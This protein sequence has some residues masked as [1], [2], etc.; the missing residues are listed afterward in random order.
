MSIKHFNQDDPKLTDFV[1]G[2]LDQNESKLIQSHIDQCA[3]CND[4]VKELRELTDL[5]STSMISD[6]PLKLPEESHQE[7]ELALASDS[8]TVSTHTDHSHKTGRAS[9]Q[10]LLIATCITI[11]TFFVMITFF[12]VNNS[13]FKETADIDTGLKYQP[14]KNIRETNIPGQQI[15]QLD[16]NQKS[17]GT[18]AGEIKTTDFSVVSKS[19][20][21]SANGQSVPSQS[22]TQ[23]SGN[24]TKKAYVIDIG[25]KAKKG[26]T[27]LANKA[28]EP[29]P[30]EVQFKQGEFT[31][32]APKFKDPAIQTNNTPSSRFDFVQ[33][34]NQPQHRSNRNI[35]LSYGGGLNK[36]NMLYER[37]P[38]TADLA[39][40]NQQTH[41]NNLSTYNSTEQYGKTPVLDTKKSRNLTAALGVNEA[42]PFSLYEGT[43]RRR[44]RQE[45][46]SFISQ[47]PTRPGYRIRNQHARI[48]ENKFLKP[49]EEPLSTFSVDVDTATYSIVRSYINKRRIPPQ[50]AVRIEEMVNY[51]TYEDAPPENQKQPFACH[52][53]TGPCPWNKKHQ[54]VRI[55]IK[56]K[57]IPVKKR[58]ACNLVFLIDV[59]GSMD[60]PDKLPLVKSGL[61]I[62]TRNLTEN[63]RISIVTYSGNAGLVLPPTDGS[64]KKEIVEKIHSLKAKGSTNGEAGLLLAYEQARKNENSERISRVI[65]CTD[66]DFNV[67]MSDDD[68]MVKLIQTEANEGI[69][70]LSVLGFGM[71]NLKDSKLEKLADNGNGNYAY[72]DNRQEAK[73]VFH[74]EING[75]LIT[76]A[77]DVKVQVEF[78]PAQVGSYRLI[79]YS[80]RVMQHHEF[81]DDSKDA[82]DIGAGHHVTVLYEIAP[83]GVPVNT[84]TDDLK[85]QKKPVQPEE[86]NNGSSEWLTCKIRYKKPEGKK[87][88]KLEFV[89]DPE[90]IKTSTLSNDFHWSSAVTAYGLLLSRS[91]YQGK[92]NFELILNLAEKGIGPDPT[93]RRLEFIDLVRKTE[94]ML[95]P[96]KKIETSDTNSEIKKELS[97][98]RQLVNEK[99]KHIGD[100]ERQLEL[101]QKLNESRKKI[102]DLLKPAPEEQADKA[103]KK[104]PIKLIPPADTLVP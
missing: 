86:K 52:L 29:D 7:I 85:Y 40:P 38:E 36:N 41:T 60:E 55:G 70:F 20:T 24:K 63:D 51:F 50:S 57:E 61:E 12:P 83:L 13:E 23:P 96:V 79:G 43:V 73:K 97:I 46:D 11:A 87:S 82:G 26:N 47:I 25:M 76:I 9:R 94:S 44:A 91:A 101:Q 2:E 37:V 54:L 71:G 33:K 77:K 48:I 56:G 74:D 58:P 62:L 72:I 42:E 99:E 53:E 75:T 32:P 35:N 6:Q 59:S 95:K 16:I 10:W 98:H 21:V 103:E 17:S 15:A 102:K 34:K 88:F 3:K 39:S 90:K 31:I 65:L 22:P 68:E 89:L 28:E 18:P 64:K 84:N 49:I 100:K 19:K 14:G 67:G 81:N 93:G 45:V 104:N 78:N 66:G 27:V 5:L 69:I 1:L 92:M 4:L 30:T 80:N 8:K